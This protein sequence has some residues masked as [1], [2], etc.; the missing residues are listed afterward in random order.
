MYKIV[1]ALLILIS[2]SVSHALCL[3]NCR[4]EAARIVDS[5]GYGSPYDA[6]S[7]SP[8]RQQRPINAGDVKNS[9]FGDMN[10]RVGHERVDV[11]T[12]SDSN[13][14]TIDASINSTIILGDMNK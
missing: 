11:K 9:V 12:D 1:L 14:N 5:Q 10:I 13:N 8:Y 3:Q 2:P 4:Q 7:N 6:V